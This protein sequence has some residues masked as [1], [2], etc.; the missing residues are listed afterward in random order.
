MSTDSELLQRLSEAVAVSGDEGAVRQIVLEHIEGNVDERRVDALGNVLAW[1]RG[2]APFGS[3]R[4][5]VKVMLAAHMDEVGFMVMG[6][7][8]DGTLIIEGVG[9]VDERQLLG[10][11]VWI[12]PGKA[13]GVIGAKP[14]HLMEA[15]EREKVVKMDALRVDIG[16]ASQEAAKSIVRIGDRG[17][18]ATRF[19]TLGPTMRG[20]ALDDRLGCATLIELL[21]GGP[22]RVDLCAAFTVQEEVGLRGARVAAYALNPE[23]AFALDAAPANDLPALEGEENTAYN[24]RLGAGPAIYVADGRTLHSRPLADHLIATAEAAGIPYQIRQPGGGGTDAGAI[25]LAREGVPAAALSTPAR[26]IHTAASLANVED[27]RNTVQLM[28][29]ALNRLTR[30][31]LIA[32][33]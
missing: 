19:Q 25:Q 5:H 12:G 8:S 26:Y 6:V 29:E 32:D 28:R 1:K 31:S 24:T 10:K 20:K 3:R 4:N 21:R 14:V 18:F 7:A 23:A 22:L 9:S 27:W 33:G 17:T 2:G 13:P 30:K 11:P 16:A 15:A